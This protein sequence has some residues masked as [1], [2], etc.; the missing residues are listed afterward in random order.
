MFQKRRGVLLFRQNQVLFQEKEETQFFSCFKK[1]KA[2][3]SCSAVQAEKS[4][5]GFVS[6][7][8]RNTKRLFQKT[9]FC[10]KKKKKHKVFVSENQVLFHQELGVVQE[11][12]GLLVSRTA[13][14]RKEQVFVS[15]KK[16]EQVF[17]SSSLFKKEEPEEKKKRTGVLLFKK[18]RKNQKKRR[19]RRKTRNQKKRRTRRKTRC[20]SEEPRC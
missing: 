20:C 18:R 16:E 7:K 17:F 5:P 12:E 14:R 4:R 6:R 10:F 2:F 11:E 9:R 8:R 15:F 1:R 3:F 19:T 13:Q